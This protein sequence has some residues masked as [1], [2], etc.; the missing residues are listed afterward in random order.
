ML[1]L[2]SYRARNNLCKSLQ[3]AIPVGISPVDDVS[4]KVHRVF[5]RPSSVRRTSLVGRAE[6]SLSGV[7]SSPWH[8]FGAASGCTGRAWRADW[9]CATDLSGEMVFWGCRVGR[10]GS[11]VVLVRLGLARVNVNTHVD[12]VGWKSFIL[13]V[14]LSPAISGFDGYN[15][16]IV[17]ALNRIFDTLGTVRQ[18]TRWQRC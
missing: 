11:R 16:R 3:L 12:D 7:T 17:K 13:N 18:H 8:A 4:D 9:R 1:R 15:L 2:A 5:Q 14:T 6:G 10:R